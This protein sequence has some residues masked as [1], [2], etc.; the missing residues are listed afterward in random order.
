MKIYYKDKLTTPTILI[1]VNIVG[2]GARLKREENTV[3][4]LRYQ[5]DVEFALLVFNTIQKSEKNKK[6]TTNL[7]IKKLC[8]YRNS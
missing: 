8:K 6:K 2:A 5:F 3:H 4:R 7:Q 1:L